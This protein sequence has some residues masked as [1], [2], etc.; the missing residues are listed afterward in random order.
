MFETLLSTFEVELKDRAERAELAVKEKELEQKKL[1]VSFE[2]PWTKEGL[3][4]V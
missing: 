2:L 3:T 4:G 1:Q